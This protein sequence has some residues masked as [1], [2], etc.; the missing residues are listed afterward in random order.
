MEQIH[1]FSDL[2]TGVARSWRS[3]PRV[4]RG[5]FGLVR[6]AAP[7]ALAVSVLL[8]LVSGVA[9]GALLLAG[10]RAL[11]RVLEAGG[12]AAPSLATT[13][14][15]VLA[16][17]VL[18]VGVS[19]LGAVALELE[20]VLGALVSRDARERV[21]RVASTV[22][23]RA[24]DSPAFHDRLER[25]VMGA[26]LRPMEVVSGV[27]SLVGALAGLVAIGFVLML[28]Q[29]WLLPLTV[30]AAVPLLLAAARAGDVQ[31]GFT[32]K[33]TANE[34]ERGYLFD[35][36]TSR[37]AAAE[38]RALDLGPSLVARHA[39]LFE[40]HIAELRHAARR[41]LRLTLHGAVASAVI[42]SGTIALLLWLALSGH[43]DL[44][45]A[46]VALG[47]VVL[48]SQRLSSLVSS[49]GQLYESA[50]FVDDMWS[51]IG[52]P[53]A[54]SLVGPRTTISG[55][56]LRM[57]DVSFTYPGAAVPA[58]SGVTLELAPGEVVA[59][60]GENGSGKTTLAKLL[61]RLYRPDGGRVLVDGRDAGDLPSDALRESV[62]VVFQDHLRLA[63]SAA[64]NIGV[65]D[66][67]RMHDRDGIVR[68]A[69]QAGIDMAL[70]ALPYGYD[71]LLA[72]EFDGGADLSLGQWQRLALARAF[73]RDAPV[74]V[75]D[76]PTAALDPRA[77]H[78]LLEHVRELL[79][80]RS[81]LVIS[82]RLSSVR[83]ADRIHVLDAGEIVE[84]GTHD[85]LMDV[86]GRYAELFRLQA[87]AYVNEPEAV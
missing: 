85:E 1:P 66:A 31:F 79:A 56:T 53:R 42:S 44:A 86:D 20:D 72:P 28:M 48:I 4:S 57:E 58:V 22:E 18:G 33:M 5:A 61:A 64:E 16:L 87:A 55:S 7:R 30:A 11:R 83:S 19:I 50:R 15:P 46:G 47:A 62:A 9:I 35:L 38:L 8:R 65:G 41:R 75:L 6:Q 40:R 13:L 69:E 73:F 67:R 45:E 27:L 49:V 70:R 3:L 2:P 71:T 12:D 32:V 24:F 36:M 14:P 10:G 80:G 60:V 59:L 76:E 21:L 26:H 77:E 23:L 78:A 52:P 68:A 29:P 74:V 25:A 54:P 51:F 43:M 37:A 63:L 81:V 84:S 34:R 17:A 82:H 39:E